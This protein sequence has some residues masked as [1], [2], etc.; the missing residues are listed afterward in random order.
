M[1]LQ[2]KFEP[3][4]GGVQLVRIGPSE[5][6]LSEGKEILSFRDQD[7]YQ[8][9]PEEDGDGGRRERRGIL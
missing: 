2:E 7:G 9:T 8:R 6:E 4:E 3:Q 1:R 5:G